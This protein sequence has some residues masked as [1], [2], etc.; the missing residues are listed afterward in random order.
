MTR[1]N[2]YLITEGRSVL[3]DQ[4]KA[5]QFIRTKAKYVIP[6]LK[7]IIAGDPWIYRG[8]ANL[9]A[10]LYLVNP[11]LTE[12]VSANTKNY[13]TWLMDN[14]PAWF[15]YPKRSRSIICTSDKDSA[16][17]N[18]A[19]IVIPEAGSRIGICPSSDLWYSFNDT[20]SQ[21]DFADMSMF[22]DVLRDIL[23]ERYSY[24]Y[25]DFVRAC[26]SIDDRKDKIGNIKDFVAEVYVQHP[27]L[28]PFLSDYY[29]GNK[30]FYK[31]IQDLLDPK[32]NRF[33]VTKVESYKPADISE[34]WTDGESLLVRF[35][36]RLEIDQLS[37]RE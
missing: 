33:K 25:K 26:I 24:T 14:S 36:S 7:G 21:Y 35:G 3:I 22:N 27:Q 28:S 29:Y 11:S 5:I 31:Y 13:Y 17:G 16:F 19:Y 12:R 20:L 18:H 34:V 4:E 32:A 30:S 1:L 37:H 2:Q 8:A 15:R 10:P 6:K 23:G 9:E